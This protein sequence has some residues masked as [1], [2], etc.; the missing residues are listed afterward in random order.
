[1]HLIEIFLIAVSLS[2]DA[3]AVA[4]GKGLSTKKLKLK[5]YIAVGLWFGG[6]QALMPTLGYILGKNF[7][8]Y[9]QSADHWIAFVLLSLIGIQ[10][11]REALKKD[12]EN[13]K[14]AD[15]SFKAMLPL[16]IATS[17]DALAAG[18]PLGVL[19]AK[20]LPS[21]SMIGII[22]F[23]LSG[24]GLKIGN[25]FGIKY[26]AKAEI[27]GGAMLILIGLHTLLNHLGIIKF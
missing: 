25:S 1:M 24:I 16:A 18:V 14:P 5:N 26:K 10:M 7:K 22:T 3:F 13:K 21:V 9:I 6:F 27:I 12:E 20:L 15:F 4:V 11:L 2:A 17:I 8:N 23:L 19:G